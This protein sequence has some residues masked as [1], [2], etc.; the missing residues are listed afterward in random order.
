MLYQAAALR[1][2]AR[3]HWR[4]VLSAADIPRLACTRVYNIITE[5][6]VSFDGGFGIKDN[7]LLSMKR[8]MAIMLNLQSR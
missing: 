7:V 2:M 5:N 6:G 4:V 8:W 3:V 1:S